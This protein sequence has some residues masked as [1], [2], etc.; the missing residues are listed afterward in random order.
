MFSNF[1]V[2]FR[3][4]LR[5]LA[6]VVISVSAPVDFVLSLVVGVENFVDIVRGVMSFCLVVDAVC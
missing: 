2:V 5:V 6:L 4:S 1:K 3:F